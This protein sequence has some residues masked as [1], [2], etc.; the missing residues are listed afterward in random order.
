MSNISVLARDADPLVVAEP[1]I[2]LV[3]A[4]LIERLISPVLVVGDQQ[5]P[6]PA[7]VRLRPALRRYLGRHI[8]IGVRPEHLQDAVVGLPA[9]AGPAAVVLHGRVRLVR[10]AG[11]DRVVH[12]ELADAAGGRQP[13]PTLV[14]RVSRRS[15]VDVGGAIMLAVD[16]RHLLAFD[17]DNGRSLW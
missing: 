12:L 9:T 5:V 3:P 10:Q 2:N 13:A 16:T 8:V 1:P 7:L 17:A 15:S 4:M 14:A 6:V 11:Q